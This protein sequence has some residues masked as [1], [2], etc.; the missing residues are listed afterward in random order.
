MNEWM[1]QMINQKINSLSARE[2]LELASQHQIPLT[3]QQAQKVIAVLRSETINIAD[4]RQV[5]RMI[6]RLKT[7]V[8][9]HVSRVIEQ[10]LQ[11]YGHLLP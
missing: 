2:L 5:E 6:Y 9:P 3:M 4:K 1:L 11:Q 10:L 8:D 7:E